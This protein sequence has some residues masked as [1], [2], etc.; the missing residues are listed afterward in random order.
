MTSA[1]RITEASTMGPSSIA[2]WL[3][4]HTRG[5]APKGIHALFGR[6]ASTSGKKRSGSKR[7]GSGHAAGSRC[8]HDGP[9]NTSVPAGIS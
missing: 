2:K 4:M 8:T 6:F 9:Q 3:P 5:P 1:A 7:S